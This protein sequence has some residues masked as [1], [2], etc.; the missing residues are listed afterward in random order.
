MKE[1]TQILL[2]FLATQ[3][4]KDIDTSIANFDLITNS[5]FSLTQSLYDGQEEIKYYQRELEG[6]FFRHGLANQS[7][8]NLIKGNH[9]RLINSEVIYGDIF[10]IKNITRMQIESFLIMF[11]LFFDDVSDNEKDLRYSVYKLH[12][13]RKQSSFP[14]KTDFAKKQFAKI[15]DEIHESEEQ[16]KSTDTYKYGT[17]KE[18][19]SLLFPQY[20]KLVKSR[21][22]FES[23]GLNKSRMG[24][25]WQIFSNYAHSEHISDRQ[26]NTLYKIDKSIKKD[27]LTVLYLNSILTSKLAVLIS[28]SFV[29]AKMKFDKLTLKEEVHLKTW[30]NLDFTKSK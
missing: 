11:Y 7:I 4:S 14:V 1:R 10:S 29:S 24:D 5:L 18:Q 19:K 20:P 27:C 12:G 30:N 22:L 3:Q 25:M 23:S 17:E 2:E 16:I 28:S 8:I 13:L 15:S 6:K 26:F 21:V 9:F